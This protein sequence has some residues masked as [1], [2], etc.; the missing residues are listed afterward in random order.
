MK[1][2]LELFGYEKVTHFDELVIVSDGQER[3]IE[4]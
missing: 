3:R 2:L 4:I 1:R